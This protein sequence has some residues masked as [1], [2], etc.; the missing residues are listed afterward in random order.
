MNS[1]FLFS[2]NISVLYAG[3]PFY[4]AYT[5]NINGNLEPC[6]CQPDELGSLLQLSGMID[7]LRGIHPD[8]ILLDNGDF[9]KT[10]PIPAANYLAWEF[11]SQLGYDVM[12]LGDQEFVEGIKFF[13]RMVGNFPVPL[14]NANIELGQRRTFTFKKYVILEKVGLKIGIT[15]ILPGEAFEFISRPE[16]EILSVEKTL[17]TVIEDLTSRCDLIILLYHA[18][19]QE[20]FRIAKKYPQIHLILAGH[21]QEQALKKLSGQTI[22]QPGYDGEYLVLLTLEKAGENFSV[23]STFLP[24]SDTIIPRPYFKDRL[25]H[26]HGNFGNEK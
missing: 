11:M 22:V 23:E 24:V 15:S 3:K 5:A 16:P 14:I 13:E 10:Y 19:Y 17:S 20:A 25:Q 4:I 7:S 26:F 8:L 1:I 12:G 9:L 6:H 2:C 21:S 18:G